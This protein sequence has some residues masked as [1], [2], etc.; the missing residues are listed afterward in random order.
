LLHF[1]TTRQRSTRRRERSP[2]R[3]VWVL[4]FMLGAVLL[5]MRQ[6]QQPETAAYL[7][8]VF[9][10][11]QDG[12]EKSLK[13]RPLPGATLTAAEG[14]SDADSDSSPQQRNADGPW[15]K[16]KD[17]AMFLEAEDEAW[18]LLWDEARRL[19]PAQLN[20]QSLGVV[21]YAQLVGQPD[22]YRGQAVTVKGRVLRESVKPAPK[23][24]VGITDYHQLVIAPIGGGD[25]PITIYCLD[26]PPGF[27]RG[28]NLQED[29][30]ITGLFFKNWSYPYDGGM[31]ISP[32]VVARTF[33]WTAPAA[34]APAAVPQRDVGPL[35]VGG[36]AAILCALGFVAW[37]SR[38]TRR[39]PAVES[40]GPDFRHLEAEQ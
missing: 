37:V 23:N 33:A 38:Q 26:L 27:P 14:E 4:L 2:T 32:V 10:A 15:A 25:F 40:P 35:L 39:P 22:V 9:A 18:F 12:E 13:R 19:E 3:G 16:V 5:M 20:R 36:I 6:L 8:R 7:G 24:S 11:P 21:S 30:S 1:G 29:V 34:R 17:N 31:G 28:E